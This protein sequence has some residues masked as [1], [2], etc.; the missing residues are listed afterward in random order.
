MKYCIILSED[1]FTSTNSVDPN[2][3]AFHLGLHCLQ[4]NP[5][6]GFPN[7]KGDIMVSYKIVSLIR[8]Y[9]NN[10]L[11]TNPWHCEEEPH[12]NHETL[13]RQTKQSNQL[14]LP[15]HDDCKTRMDTK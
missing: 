14:S 3:V 2:Y 11:Q 15:H 4:K 8:K 6:G 13:E 5:F 9:H 7:T 12:N 1:L 10:K